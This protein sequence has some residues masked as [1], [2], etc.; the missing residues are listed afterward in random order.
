M[1]MD[2][3]VSQPT[4]AED[5]CSCQDILARNKRWAAQM[6]SERP[7]YFTRLLAQQ[8]PK[9]MWIGCSDSRV[10][11]NQVMG[12]DPGEVFVHRNVANLMVPSDLNSLS[13][14]QFAVQRLKVRHVMVV[15][16]YGC[17]GVSAALSGERVGLAD[18]WLQHIR[19]TRDTHRGRLNACPEAQRADF[20]CELNVL[21]QVVHVA[22]STVVVDAWTAGQP[23]SIHGWVYG[24]HDGVIQ[25]LQMTTDGSADLDA[26]HAK[27]VQQAFA[28]R[29]GGAPLAT[30]FAPD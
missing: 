14:L 19:A 30:V 5:E 4:D 3:P 25:D 27:A 21:R 29:A 8:A 11:A 23:L 12:L 22:Q 9:H 16:H 26:L 20:L 1:D 15:G 13:T 10:P 2:R 24:L 18:N 7:D 28:R 6:R 17:G